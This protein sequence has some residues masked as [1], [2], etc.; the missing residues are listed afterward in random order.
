MGMIFVYITNP[1]KKVAK[2]I[3]K[4]LL[5]ARLIACANIFPIESMYWWQGKLMEDSEFVLIAKTSSQNFSKVKAA[6][7]KLHP[8][9]VPC[10]IKLPVSANRKYSDWLNA[11]LKRSERKAK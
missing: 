6:V 1:S 9:S 7:E 5:G 11:E 2:G 4:H 10:I 3:A 8:Y